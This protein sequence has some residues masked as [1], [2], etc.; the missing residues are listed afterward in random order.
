MTAFE[1]LNEEK[2]NKIIDAGITV[3]GKYDYKRASVSLVANEAGI[4]KSMI[5]HYFGS[6]RGLYEYL[7]EY[8]FQTFVSTYVEGGMTQVSD[9][10]DRFMM[11]SRM[12]L[13]VMSKHRFMFDFILNFYIE[14][15]TEV[16]DYVMSTIEKSKKLG[17]Q[18]TLVDVDRHKFKENIKIEDVAKIIQWL[19]DGYMNQVKM[20]PYF[21]LIAID[22]ELKSTIMLL[23]SNFYKPDYL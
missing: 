19:I 12:Q 15:D 7:M 1:E 17:F 14:R 16:L 5:F 9:F 22:N 21:D 11:F 4:S 3:F 2:K 6:K 23:Q 10:F 18:M 13:E 8:S 20:Q